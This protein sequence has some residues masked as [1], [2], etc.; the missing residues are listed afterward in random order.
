MEFLIT[1]NNFEIKINENETVITEED[2]PGQNPTNK[3]NPPPQN[4]LFS[5]F[6]RLDDYYLINNLKIIIPQDK[7]DLIQLSSIHFQTTEIGKWQKPLYFNPDGKDVIT[8][9]NDAISIF[10]V[11]LTDYIKFDFILLSSEVAISDLVSK[12]IIYSQYLYSIPNATFLLALLNIKNFFQNV[13]IDDNTQIQTKDNNYYCSLYLTAT[14]MIQARL[15]IQAWELLTTLQ[16]II[17]EKISSDKNNNLDFFYIMFEIEKKK[18]K[19]EADNEKGDVI[20]IDSIILEEKKN[21]LNIEDISIFI[22]HIELIKAVCM[23]EHGHFYVFL[24]CLKNCIDFYTKHD[25]SILN[26]KISLAKVNDIYND[27]FYVQ[28]FLNDNGEQLSDILIRFLKNKNEILKYSTLKVFEFILDYNPTILIKYISKIMNFLF[29]SNS[30]IK[31][32]VSNNNIINQL[33]SDKELFLSKEDFASLLNDN[34]SNRHKSKAENDKKNNKHCISQILQKQINYTLDTIINNL[35]SFHNEILTDILLNNSSILFEIIASNETENLVNAIAMKVI[36]KCFENL[37]IT[38][39]S[40]PNKSYEFVFRLFIMGIKKNIKEIFNDYLSIQKKVTNFTQYPNKNSKEIKEIIHNS[41]NIAG[42]ISTL[43]KSDELIDISNEIG[44]MIKQIIEQLSDDMINID[45]NNNLLDYVNVSIDKLISYVEMNLNDNDNKDF[46]QCIF[47]LYILL[48]FVICLLLPKNKLEYK[49][50]VNEKIYSTE[51]VDNMNDFTQKMKLFVSNLFK[52]EKLTLI[53]RKSYLLFEVSI[54]ALITCKEVFNSVFQDRSNEVFNYSSYFVEQYVSLNEYIKSNGIFSDNIKFILKTLKL[55]ELNNEILAKT[56]KEIFIIFLSN[57]TN[58]YTEESFALFALITESLGKSQLIDKELFTMITNAI[59]LKSNYKGNSFKQCY[60]KY[61]E[62]VFLNEEYYKFFNE[63][64]LEEFAQFNA[65]LQDIKGYSNNYLEF[66]DRIDLA[67]KYHEYFREMIIKKKIDLLKEK[68]ETKDLLNEISKIAENCDDTIRNK[69]NNL[70]DSIIGVYE[71]VDFLIDKNEFGN[72]LC[73]YFTVIN[74]KSNFYLLNENIKIMEHFVCNIIGKKAYFDDK[75]SKIFIN[76]FDSIDLDLVKNIQNKRIYVNI[77][78]FHELLCSTKI[79]HDKINEITRYIEKVINHYLQ[80]NDEFK[81]LFGLDL[82]FLTNGMD[83]N[84][85]DSIYL[86]LKNFPNLIQTMVNLI[87]T[88]NNYKIKIL[89]YN[90]LDNLVKDF[91]QLNDKKSLKD[92]NSDNIRE[93]IIT[94]YLNMKKKIF[95]ENTG[96]NDNN[97]DNEKNEGN[98]YDDYLNNIDNN[99]NDGEDMYDDYKYNPNKNIPTHNDQ[100]NKD[101][102]DNIENIAQNPVLNIIKEIN[103]IPIIENSNEI[104]PNNN[105]RRDLTKE[106]DDNLSLEDLGVVEV[107]DE[108]FDNLDDKNI[109][110]LKKNCDRSKGISAKLKTNQN[111]KSLLMSEHVTQP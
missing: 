89:F 32:D 21:Y 69:L 14:S 5:L 17:V 1:S 27:K 29:R 31:Q 67:K 72:A 105:Q 64:L 87:M 106:E 51:K 78:K 86:D 96:K 4:Q 93:Y 65:V 83:L 85:D 79:F 74:K 48:E 41:N 110:I 36:K 56:I 60:T 91:E 23:Y 37:D 111:S 13:D 10:C 42:L 49:T 82:L 40:K 73:K 7:D 102:S 103:N 68:Q 16:K 97:E 104:A 35:D 30:S 24:N 108:I 80:S 88:S 26:T 47:Y 71:K 15:F 6:L 76:V 59:V 38:F 34:N 95:S 61:F 12:I 81:M 33:F 50:K 18:E 39:Y 99:I 3:I 45:K 20:E 101:T 54:E 25:Y 46:D 9:D 84:K 66:I 8:R 63:N 19:I 77:M 22:T 90:V 98:D 70:V 11:G 57:F 107:E 52:I 43:Q 53:N 28:N 94:P 109:P 2:F 62:I 75:L 44:N 92:F 58:Y 100:E 55:C